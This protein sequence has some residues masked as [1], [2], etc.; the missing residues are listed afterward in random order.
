MTDTADQEQ[1]PTLRFR[2]YQPRS[3]EL[4]GLAVD[5]PVVPSVE[6][7]L[8]SAEVHNDAT[9]EPL[10]NLAPKRPNWD[11]KRDLE[12]QMKRLRAQTDRAILR[13]IAER[14]AAEQ[15]QAE[16]EVPKEGDVDLASAVSRHQKLDARDEDDEPPHWLWYNISSGYDVSL[17]GRPY[18]AGDQGAHVRS[19]ALGTICV[20]LL[21]T[22]ASMVQRATSTVWK[23]PHTKAQSLG[24]A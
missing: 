6:E 15:Q 1:G 13:L 4:Q 19:A 14:V 24:K 10:L 11:L 23:S 9:Q 8:D 3:E 22:C 12:P 18:T 17:T 20:F 2:N 5:K 16:G 7:T 21:S